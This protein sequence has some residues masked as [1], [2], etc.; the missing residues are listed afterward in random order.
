MTARLVTPAE[1]ADSIHRKIRHKWAEAV[2]AEHGIGDAVTFSV[3]LRPGLTT[4]TAVEQ[5]GYRRWYDWHAAWRAFDEQYISNTH[6]V[7]VIRKPLTIQRVTDVYPATLI[8]TD[9]TAAVALVSHAHNEPVTV[10]IA[11]ARAVATSLQ[12]AGATL[13]TTTLKATYR[14]SEPDTTVLLAAVR[15]LHEH[16]DVS[17]WTAR[18]L[19][20]AGMH[21]KW[22]ETHDG[23]LRAVA[24]RDVRAELRP[25]PAVVHLTYVDP[26]YAASGRRRHDAWTTGDVH[27]LAYQPRNVL[28]VENRDC[29]LWF[30]PARNTIVVEGNGKAAASLVANITWIRLAEHVIYWG[31]IDADGYA[32]LDRLRAEMSTPT[33]NGLPA[34]SVQSILMDAT[35]LHNHA[36]HGVNHDKT[37]RPIQ[38]SSTDF[39][40]LTPGEAAA[41]D[42]IATAGPALFRRIEQERIPLLHAAAQLQ[43]LTGTAGDHSSPQDPGLLHG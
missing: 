18:Q 35:D 10:D 22:L 4:G 2:C 7:R 31:D 23:L 6:G 38:P 28:I 29:R 11:R 32:I 40:H 5:I 3:P 39:A 24:G 21:S 8:S 43:S 26:D 15:W 37:G 17:A 20:V 13:T 41:Y 36:H 12:A 25:R 1:A 14:L 27:E 16:P 9:L 19:P 42:A 30:P 33:P 34:K